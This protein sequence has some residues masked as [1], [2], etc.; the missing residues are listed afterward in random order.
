M[1]FVLKIVSPQTFYFLQILMNLN[2]DADL[3]VDFLNIIEAE[4]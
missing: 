2:S 3:L 1:N 4:N